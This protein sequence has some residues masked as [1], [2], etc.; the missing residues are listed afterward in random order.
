MIVAI[1]CADFSYV[2]IPVGATDPSIVESQERRGIRLGL[3]D[4]DRAEVCPG[5]AAVGGA[6]GF[7]G[8]VATIRIDLSEREDE[9]VPGELNGL[10][11]DPSRLGGLGGDPGNELE[12]QAAVRCLH[13]ANLFLTP[14]SVA[15]GDEDE[16]SAPSL[17]EVVGSGGENLA[18]QLGVL[19][20][21]VQSVRPSPVLSA[22]V[23]VEE[24]PLG[25]VVP[26]VSRSENPQSEA[27]V[28]EVEWLL[29]CLL[30]VA[31]K[32]AI[33]IVEESR[34]VEHLPRPS[35]VE[36]A[37]EET[38]LSTANVVALSKGEVTLREAYQDLVTPRP[39]PVVGGPTVKPILFNRDDRVFDVRRLVAAY[40]AVAQHNETQS[41]ACAQIF[42]GIHSPFRRND[43]TS[44][45]DARA[46]T[47]YTRRGAF[48][49]SVDSEDAMNRVQ[50]LSP[51]L[52]LIGC[53]VPKGTDAVSD[54]EQ[55]IATR[56]D[57]VHR[58]RKLGT[59]GIPGLLLSFRDPDDDIHN[60]AGYALVWF[61]AEVLPGLLGALSDE[62]PAIRYRATYLL[63]AMREQASPAVSA[64]V[65]ALADPDEWVPYGA[66]VALGEIGPT[67]ELAVPDLAAR[68][69]DE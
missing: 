12:C 24:A 62:D 29:E 65:S 44:F 42:H 15:R 5:I 18:F 55:K 38:V 41:N 37:G 49:V 51:L 60:A 27:G 7:D 28:G 21:T 54:P 63:G 46:R 9:L 6:I 69:K 32:L 13:A 61:G 25:V 59:E 43:R 31:K 56:L 50:L 20:Q 11:H 36:A 22:V 47:V 48:Y 33:L 16:T 1:P 40:G 3:H 4:L 35:S 2:P 17:H 45:E 68:L 23:R 64:L 34:R 58:L 19:A 66:A 10:T 57:E 26:V 67:A 14:P 8:V 39:D 53:A 30:A 52:L